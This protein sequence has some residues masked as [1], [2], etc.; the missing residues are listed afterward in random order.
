MTGGGGEA[1]I[2]LFLFLF[3]ESRTRNRKNFAKNPSN[4]TR[5][6]LYLFNFESEP[7]TEIE[8]KVCFIAKKFDLPANERSAVRDTSSPVASLTKPIRRRSKS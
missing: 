3:P 4:D 6:N 2:F 7:M 5:V 8:T 1:T